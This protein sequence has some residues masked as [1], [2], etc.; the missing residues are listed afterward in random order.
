[1]PNKDIIIPVMNNETEV[2]NKIITSQANKVIGFDNQGN[3][4]AIEISGSGQLP[5]GTEGGVLRYNEISNEWQQALSVKINDEY[6]YEN[7]EGQ[8]I[9]ISPNEMSGEGHITINRWGYQVGR[10][11]HKRAI[12][13][14]T[15]DENN[16]IQFFIING[17]DTESGTPTYETLFQLNDYNIQYKGHNISQS[18]RLQASEAISANSIVNIWNDGGFARIRKADAS[19]GV[20]KQADGIIIKSVDMYEYVDVYY[21]GILTGLSGLIIGNK[22]YLNTAGGVTITP[23]TTSGYITQYIGKAIS[24]TE[25]L[26]VYSEPIIR[27]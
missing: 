21:S 25:I 14:I 12:L 16:G 19:G 26:Y 6:D 8:G 2:K 18:I 4:Q 23:P 20:A 13:R 15:T 5:N 27:E 7:N 24:D 22:Y 17:W 3:I 1:M 9:V 11:W 10:G